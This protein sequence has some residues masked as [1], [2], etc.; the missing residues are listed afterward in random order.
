MNSIEPD[1]PSQAAL[2]GPAAAAAVAPAP[3]PTESAPTEAAPAAPA[4]CKNCHA[5]LLGRF[6]VNC[7]Q[8]AD[9]HVPS[10]LELLHEM[11]EG[12]THS[13][14]RLWRTLKLLWFKLVPADLHFSCNAA[15][16]PARL[17]RHVVQGGGPFLRLQHR[18][19]PHLCRGSRVRS[20]AVVR[21]DFQ[22]GRAA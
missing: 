2:P 5:V 11:L 3:T 15:G 10:T 16:V 21:C 7:S 13:D 12:L 9:V 19:C 18:V 14:S 4:Q 17:A 1:G 6:C 8:A 22:P 20:T